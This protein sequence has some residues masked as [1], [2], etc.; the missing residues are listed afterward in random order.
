MVVGGERRLARVLARQQSRRERHAHDDPDPAARGLGEEHAGGALAERVEDDLHGRHVRVLD[1]LERLLDALD[2]DA[3]GGDPPLADHRL[4]VLED[5]RVVVEVG[6][7]AVQLHEVE[8]L[9]AEVLARAVVPRPE[10]LGRVVLDGL[11]QAP[12][13]LRG[14]GDRLALALAQQ[15]SDQPLRAAV[16]V[17]V[18]GVEEGHAGVGGRVQRRHRRV[19]LHVA[20]VGA[21]LP[22]AEA[23]LGHFA[24]GRAKGTEPHRPGGCQSPRQGSCR[25]RRRRTWAAALGPALAGEDALLVA[26]GAEDAR[27]DGE[28]G[29]VPDVLADDGLDAVEDAV[30]HLEQLG[31]VLLGPRRRG[32][33]VHAGHRVGAVLGDDDRLAVLRGPGVELGLQPA[34]GGG[35]VAGGLVPAVVAV[36]HDDVEEV[37]DDVAL[38]RRQHHVHEADRPRRVA[39]AAP[40]RRAARSTRARRACRTRARWRCSTA[41]RTGGSC[42]ARRARGSPG[43]ARPASRR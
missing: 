1:R 14:D 29:E 9:H 41:R 2:A 8:R 40:P 23:D 18:G 35:Q 28:V 36:E 22:R 16:A 26:V 12:A 6:R 34:L 15:A 25:Q 3:V 10:V 37:G 38:G 19:L 5:L 32:D 4:Q 31:L 11:V 17:D 21:D 43:G 30:G 13:H 20:P 33:A 39:A 42:R 27:G 7:R 24:L